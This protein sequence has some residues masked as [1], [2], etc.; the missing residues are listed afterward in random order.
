MPCALLALLL[1]GGSH[2]HTLKPV[3]GV[4]HCDAYFALFIMGSSG[5]TISLDI[6]IGLQDLL[7]YWC[8]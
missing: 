4:I 5:Q 7:Y 8:D 1:S 2:C 6:E 3:A